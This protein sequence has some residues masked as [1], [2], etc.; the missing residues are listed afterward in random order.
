[1]THRKMLIG[2]MAFFFVLWFLLPL[3][4]P[5][6]ARAIYLVTLP[7][8]HLG[9]YVHEMGHGLGALLTGG[10]FHWFEMELMRGGVAITSGGLK[11]AVLLGGLLGPTIF[12]AVLLQVS[13][14]ADSV[15][16]AVIAAGVFFGIGA[17][18][19]VKP[20]FLSR[21]QFPMLADWSPVN[22]FIALLLAAA[23][24][25]TWKLTSLPD[26]A[27]RFFLQG[28]GILM[29]FSGFSDTRY[30]FMY[31]RLPNGMYS[32]SRMV[33]SLFWGSPE[34]TPFI[35]FFITAAAIS[36]LNLGLM[37]WGVYRAIRLT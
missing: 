31:E 7:V 28:L 20:L 29:C 9:V 37:F 11:L 16:W 18:F 23:A 17:Y 26:Q 5:F 8:R 13:T 25:L 6:A 4:F 10:R 35:L 12:G 33:A 22:L 1:M 15:R 19:M 21:A 24:F 3:L 27:Q 30:I 2:L 32:D 36:L 14:R 34:S